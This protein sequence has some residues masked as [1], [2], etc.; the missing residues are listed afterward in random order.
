MA[1]GLG[2]SRVKGID[3]LMN[4]PVLK[5]DDVLFAKIFNENSYPYKFSLIRGKNCGKNIVSMHKAEIKKKNN[6]RIFTIIISQI[7]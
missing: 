5:K 3:Y 4:S 7:K 6:K 2:K 1:M